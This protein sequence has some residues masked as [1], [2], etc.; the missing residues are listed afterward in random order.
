M[1]WA[2]LEHLLKGRAVAKFNQMNPVQGCCTVKP[3]VS[4]A[5][6][7]SRGSP[8]PHNGQKHPPFYHQLYPHV[9]YSLAL[10]SS[11]FFSGEMGKS[12]RYKKKYLQL[13]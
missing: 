1:K 11:Y 9:S 6:W 7:T 3:S 10:D 5:L 2:F 12:T 4:L 13:K 8:H